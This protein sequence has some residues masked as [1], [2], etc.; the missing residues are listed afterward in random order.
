MQRKVQTSQRFVTY[1]AAGID[2][3]GHRPSG[4]L[5][6]RD[7]TGDQSPADLAGVGADHHDVGLAATAM[8]PETSVPTDRP[9]IAGA[10]GRELHASDEVAIQ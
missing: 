3:V 9:G 10:D 5:F 2:Q 4:H 8:A 6:G 1:A 7:V